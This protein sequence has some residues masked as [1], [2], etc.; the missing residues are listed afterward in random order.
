MIGLV[1]LWGGVTAG[2]MFDIHVRVTGGRVL[3]EHRVGG[4]KGDGGCTERQRVAGEV[5]VE[6]LILSL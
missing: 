2:R 3:I 1:C 4:G 5:S 6:L